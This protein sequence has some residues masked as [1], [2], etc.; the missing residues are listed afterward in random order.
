MIYDLRFCRQLKNQGNFIPRLTQV[1]Y[2]LM[3]YPW[4]NKIRGEKKIPL[5]PKPQWDLYLYIMQNYLHFF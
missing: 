5:K 1:Y 2:I 3:F 4:G